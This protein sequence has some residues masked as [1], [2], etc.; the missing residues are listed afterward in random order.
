MRLF[1]SG[2]SSLSVKCFTAQRLWGASWVE[3]F[4]PESWWKLMLIVMVLAVINIHLWTQCSICDTPLTALCRDLLLWRCQ[5][6]YFPGGVGEILRGVLSSLHRGKFIIESHDECVSAF[7]VANLYTFI[8]FI[9]IFTTVKFKNS[10]WFSEWGSWVSG[11]S[12][13]ERQAVLSGFSISISFSFF[14]FS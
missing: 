12:F 14:F 8:L 10:E 11:T 1:C 6:P 9:S 5:Q 3:W 2:P 13:L 7:I 4:N